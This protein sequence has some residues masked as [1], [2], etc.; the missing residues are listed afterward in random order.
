MWTGF[1]TNIHSFS[2]PHKTTLFFYRNAIILLQTTVTNN[3]KK[4]T[5]SQVH[6][7]HLKNST[8]EL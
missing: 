6:K 8:K 5:Q 1:Q 7:K 4:T 2:F 3:N